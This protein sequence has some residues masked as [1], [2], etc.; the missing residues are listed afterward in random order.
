MSIHD[1]DEK[2]VLD[3]P[4]LLVRYPLCTVL[5]SGEQSVIRDCFCYIVY[6]TRSSFDEQ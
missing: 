2:G 3:F 4:I 1:N 6:L 5:A